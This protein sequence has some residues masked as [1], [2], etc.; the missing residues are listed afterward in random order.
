V[1]TFAS[2]L[3]KTL[4]EFRKKISAGEAAM[5]EQEAPQADA[6][7]GGVSRSEGEA[8]GET[9]KADEELT[10]AGAEGEAAGG[11]RGE[12][13][14]EGDEGKKNSHRRGLKEG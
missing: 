8:V 7:G 5:K 9:A 3:D 2:R 6:E 14:E 10:Q 1:D 12:K 13:G 4:K 11:G